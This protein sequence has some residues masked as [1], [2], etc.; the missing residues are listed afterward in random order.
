[1]I[2]LNIN[3]RKEKELFS[4][5]NQDFN[6]YLTKKYIYTRVNSYTTCLHKFFYHYIR[7]LY[8]MHFIVVFI[9]KLTKRIC[10]NSATRSCVNIDAK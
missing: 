6:S 4:C 9:I 8:S 10:E 1:M 5:N 2:I 3:C 7:I